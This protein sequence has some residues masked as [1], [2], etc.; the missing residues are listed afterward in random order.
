M[1]LTALGNAVDKELR[2][3]RLNTSGHL[4]DMAKDTSQLRFTVTVRP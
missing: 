1:Q 2:C 4:N 3:P